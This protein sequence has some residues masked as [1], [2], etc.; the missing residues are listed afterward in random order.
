MDRHLLKLEPPYSIIY[1]DGMIGRHIANIICTD[2][3]Q[4]NDPDADG[5]YTETYPVLD[6]GG[7]TPAGSVA[8]GS[9]VEDCRVILPGKAVECEEGPIL[10]LYQFAR[11]VEFDSQQ[12]L[13]L[14]HWNLFERLAGLGV[15]IVP[16]TEKNEH[17]VEY[18]RMEYEI[19]LSMSGNHEHLSVKS[20]VYEGFYF[21]ADGT[22]EECFRQLESQRHTYV[23]IFDEQRLFGLKFHFQ[24]SDMTCLSVVARLNGEELDPKLKMFD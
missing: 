14:E 8:A 12:S 4:E 13:P 18:E 24:S 7:L 10:T 1:A 22:S 20:N 17:G 6:C 15:R 11:L 23:A 16:D 2:Y 19:S 5:L 21:Y 9:M 3:I